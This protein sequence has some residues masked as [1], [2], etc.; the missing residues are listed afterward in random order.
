LE[1][2]CDFRRYHKHSHAKDLSAKTDEEKRAVLG[3]AAT[4][5]PTICAIPASDNE[6]SDDEEERAAKK[7]RKRE[8]KEKK[9]KRS[10][11]DSD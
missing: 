5:Y 2:L 8:K 11:D 6:E 10:S 9:R 3:A 7:A 1:L 4:A